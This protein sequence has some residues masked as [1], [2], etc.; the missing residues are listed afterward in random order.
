[1]VVAVVAGRTDRDDDHNTFFPRKIDYG[2][3][4]GSPSLPVGW[5]RSDRSLPIPRVPNAREQCNALAAPRTPARPLHQPLTSSVLSSL[6]LSQGACSNP[7]APRASTPTLTGGGS[8]DGSAPQ[9]AQQ[10]PPASNVQCIPPDAPLSGG[11]GWSPH[12]LFRTLWTLTY[13]P[14]LWPAAMQQ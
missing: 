11:K 2:S 12:V 7:P 1:M 5:S 10:H 4:E 8:H 9:R 3:N 13:I 14:T 6:P